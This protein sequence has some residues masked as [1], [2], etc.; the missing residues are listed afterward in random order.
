MYHDSRL[1]EGLSIDTTFNRPYSS[2][3]ADI[4][5]QT[6][7]RRDDLGSSEPWPKTSPPLPF[8]GRSSA[9][10]SPSKLT[11][12][13][14]K[15]SWYNRVFEMIH[16]KVISPCAF[17]CFWSHHIYIDMYI[18]LYLDI[19]PYMDIYICV[20][21]YIYIYT[22]AAVSNEKRKPRQFSLICLPFAHHANRSLL[23][24]RLLEVIRLQTD[25][26]NLPFYTCRAASKQVVVSF[27]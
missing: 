23:F 9:A 5:S 17:V 11:G 25:K 24:V 8:G 6:A 4:L 15:K 18:Y 13:R 26:T 1:K 19:S 7:S 20:S 16:L 21:M 3:L 14:P 27:I 10:K 2:E 22:Y 12:T